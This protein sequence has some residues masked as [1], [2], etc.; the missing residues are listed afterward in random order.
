MI[1][2]I[3]QIFGIIGMLSTMI[4]FQIKSTK[5]LFLMQSFSGICFALNYILLGAYTGC[6]INILNIGRCLIM[7]GGK[8]MRRYPILITIILSYCI[9]TLLTYTNI[10]SILALIAQ[11][12]GTIS[13]WSDDWKKIR[14]A[15]LFAVSPMWLAHNIFVFSIGGIVSEIINMISTSVSLFRFAKQESRE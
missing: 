15:Q 13:M 2:T 5:K 9:A 3:A 6:V 8:K 11:I 4:S 7:S 1:N 12:I 10:F 14:I